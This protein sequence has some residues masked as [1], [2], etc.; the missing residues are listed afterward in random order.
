MLCLKNYITQKIKQCKWIYEIT[1]PPNYHLAVMPVQ[2]VELK[3]NQTATLVFEDEPYSGFKIRKVDAHT[4]KGLAG[5]VF[6]IH[7]KDGA[8]LRREYRSVCVKKNRQQGD[9]WICADWR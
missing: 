8:L 3:A 9:T 5:A 1:P 6:T 7:I 2:T 4:G